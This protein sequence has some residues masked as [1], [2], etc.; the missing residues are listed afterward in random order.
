MVGPSS[1]NGIEISSEKTPVALITTLDL[2]R[3]FK[4][5]KVSCISTPSTILFFF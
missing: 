1:N 4:P 5:D 2:I 3:Y